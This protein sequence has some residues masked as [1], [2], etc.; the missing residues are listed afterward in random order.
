MSAGDTA[1]NTAHGA[2]WLEQTTASTRRISTFFKTCWEAL[3]ERREYQR[4]QADLF[5]LSDGELMDIGIMRGEIDY[6]ASNR[7]VDP[8]GG[9]CLCGPD[10]S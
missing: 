8:R 10:R 7:S 9:R 6:V 2:T 1:M 3:Q 4:L 5:N